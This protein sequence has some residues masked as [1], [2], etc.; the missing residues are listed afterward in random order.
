[1]SGAHPTDSFLESLASAHRRRM[2]KI[3]R[4]ADEPV[5][6]A[7]LATFTAR[8]GSSSAS[9]GTGAD[10]VRI[11]Q[12]HVHLP[13]LVDAG[14]VDWDRERRLISATDDGRLDDGLRTALEEI[15]PGGDDEIASLEAWLACPSCGGDATL[16]SGGRTA[17]AVL[18]C[19]RC[20]HAERLSIEQRSADCRPNRGVDDGSCTS[21]STGNTSRQST[22][23]AS[24]AEQ[25]TNGR[26]E[27]ERALERSN[28]QLEQFA[29][30]ASHDLQEPLRMVSGYL[31]LIEDR[32]GDELDEDAQE[33]IEFATDG[34][35]RMR[36]MIDGLLAYSRVERHGYSFEP[37]D[38]DDVM[39]DVRKNLELRIDETGATITVAELPDVEGDESQLRQLFQN[40]VSNA[41]EYGGDE[42]PV[43]CVSAE[44]LG[45]EWVI[46]VRDEG[47][48]IDPADRDRIFEVFQRLHSYHESSG[49]GIGLAICKRIADRHGGEIWVE[50]TPGDGSTFSVTLPAVE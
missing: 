43:V 37:V 41:I 21:V 15:D 40:L 13:A 34:A 9:E 6:E 22:T 3:L 47:V 50:S 35:E 32:Y 26:S 24:G 33:Y 4:T 27:R 29:Y 20:D 30:A 10:R 42:S 46:S 12:H 8:T 16:R 19:D 38:L 45:D 18:E 14:L 28:E 1:M 44:R 49:T 48:G 23:D 5:S 7:E 31:R 36:M 39:T 2:L 11:E 25:A 17:G